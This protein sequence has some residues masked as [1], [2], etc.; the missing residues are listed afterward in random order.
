MNFE[1]EKWQA[2]KQRLSI[3]DELEGK[4]V[5]KRPFGDFIDVGEGFPA[6]LEIIVMQVPLKHQDN[7]SEYYPLGSTVQA[8]IVA[9]DDANRQIRVMQKPLNR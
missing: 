1:E 7:P 4:V 9:F 3:G 8:Q 6:L 5:V 2:L